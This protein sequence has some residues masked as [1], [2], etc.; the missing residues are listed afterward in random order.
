MYDVLIVGAGLSGLLA[1]RALIPSGRRIAILDKGRSPGG[2]LATRRIGPGRADHGAQFFTVR[3]AAFRSLV[4][5]WAQQARVYPWSHGWSDGSLAGPAADGHPRYAAQG[6]MNALARSIA[7]EVS[8]GGVEIRCNVQ[9]KSLAQE[10]GGWIATDREGNCFRGQTCVLTMPAPQALAILD[11][12]AVTLHE[13][14]RAALDRIQYAPCLCAMYWLDQ[15]TRIP[16]PGAIQRPDREITWIADNHAKGI[17]PEASIVTMHAAPG[18][19]GQ[20]YHR[21]DEE[22]LTEF[23][24]ELA[25]WL[26]SGTTILQA[27]I[28]RWRYALPTVLHPDPYLCAEGLPPLYFGGDAFGSPRVE[29]AA[30]SGLAI[31]AAILAQES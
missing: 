1:A 24:S 19:S 16:C 30:L 8:A 29:G 7:T 4:D 26:A 11:A 13:A 18:W 2:R 27:E 17:S 14:E 10:N 22:L 21:H 12:G 28:K 23:S 15:P 31:G 6:G 9:V 20:N 25:P 3:S 5:G